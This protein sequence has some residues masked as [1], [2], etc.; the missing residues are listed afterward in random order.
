[1]PSIPS[2]GDPDVTGGKKDVAR[3]RGLR[4]PEGTSRLNDRLAGWTER[5]T[6]PGLKIEQDRLC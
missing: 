3:G 5:T 6:N 4:S 1:M 2:N